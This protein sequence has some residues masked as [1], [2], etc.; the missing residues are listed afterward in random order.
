MD[1]SDIN[2]KNKVLLKIRQASDLPAMTETVNVIN[3]FKASEDT[4]VTD[5]ANILLKDYA[6]TTKILKVVNSVHFQQSGQVTTIS[7]AIFLMGVDHIKNI[8]MTLMLFDQMR[9]H[10]PQSEIKD[11]ILQAFCG[12]D[13]AQKLD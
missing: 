4:S 13:I 7:R 1:K 3:K 8:A 5:L 11:A 12:G 2:Q 10:S 9:K 6:L